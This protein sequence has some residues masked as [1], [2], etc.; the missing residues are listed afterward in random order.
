MEVLYID[1]FVRGGFALAP[2]Q[3]A[4]LGG[5][6]FD[7]DILNSETQDDG[8]DHTEGHLQI[9]INDFFGTNRYQM[10]TLWGNKVQSL[11]DIGD[12]VET[13]LATIGLGQ[14][15]TRDNFEQQHQFQAIAKI[16]FDIVD[17]GAGLAQMTV[18]PGGE[19]LKKIKFEND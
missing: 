14:S 19:G 6:L 2:Q 10:D 4:L 9:A 13:H 8:P 17:R 11:I 3:Q 1:I 7:R 5:H 12:F 15:L 18:T 16:V